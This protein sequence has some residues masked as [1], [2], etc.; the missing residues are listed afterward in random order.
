MFLLCKVTAEH[1]VVAVQL[2][3]GHVVDV[4]CSYVLYNMCSLNSFVTNT[5]H[6]EL[7]VYYLSKFD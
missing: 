5:V 6:G 4:S 1:A 2:W 7:K 3:M